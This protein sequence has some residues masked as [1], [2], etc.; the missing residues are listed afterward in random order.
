M[1]PGPAATDLK[2]MEKNEMMTF[3]GHLEALRRMLFR[4]IISVAAWGILLF[5]FKERL[6]DIVLAPHDADF[7]IYR[8]AQRLV[9]LCG[10]DVDVGAF[11]VQLINT[12]LASQFTA[13]IK[14]SACLGL[15]LASPYVVYELYRFVSPALYDNERRA[16]VWVVVSAYALFIIGV[17]VNY[18]VIFPISFRFLATYQVSDAVAN[19]IA[20]SSYISTFLMLSFMLG[21]VFELPVVAY[22]L[23][24][25]GIARSSALRRGRKV[26]LLVILVIAAIVTPPDVF[27]QIIVTVPLYALYELSIV[28]VGRC[29]RRRD[30]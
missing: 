18:F 13:H 29:E 9:D 25:A 5:C 27:S 26:A 20:L 4:V 12:E 16:S 14:V 7:C 10:M 21:V 28:I 11:D 3:G 19:T 24:R 8:L 2:A 30:A 1:H 23:A 22:F 6:F 15:L 17:L